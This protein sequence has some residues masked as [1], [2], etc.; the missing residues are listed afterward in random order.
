M[1]AFREVSMARQHDRWIPA[2]TMLAVLG[3]FG[4]SQ[5]QE[6]R[7]DAISDGVLIG[8]GAGVAAGVVLSLA[9]EEICSP[10]ACAYLG[11]LAGGLIGLVVDKKIGRP[12]PVEPGSYIDD[13]LGDGALI[14]AL[15]GMGIVLL[16]A[17]VR[18]R[19]GTGR[20]PCTSEGILRN[21]VRGARWVAIAGLLIDA[22][23]PSKVPHAKG[24]VSGRSQRRHD[25]S[26]TLRF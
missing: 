19:K 23:I 6:L 7:R 13:G 3:A 2:L 12:G 1:L 5:A 11:G 15:S 14:G 10:G 17:S 9:T 18:C 8:G 21:M 25:V 22:A 24:L 4:S 20:P 26:F 16:E